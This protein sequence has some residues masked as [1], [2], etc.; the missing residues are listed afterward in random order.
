MLDWLVTAQRWLYGDLSAQLSAFASTRNWMTLA[1]VLPLGI[2]F[3]AIHALTPGHSKGILAS[4]LIGSRLNVFRAAG[5]A[6]T[7]AVVHVTSAVILALLAAPLITRTIGGV[8]RAP[9]LDLISRS[10]LLAIGVWLVARAIRGKSHLHGEGIA[11]GVVAGLVP[12]PLTLFAM[13]Y[14]LSRDV[15]EAGIAFAA[16]M[17]I[18]VGIT[19]SLVALAA[20]LT[21]SGFRRFIQSTTIEHVSRTVEALGGLLLAVTAIWSLLR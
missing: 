18:G 19:L 17:M 16:A 2:V 15:P 4:Y 5:V 10:I 9:A 20:V 11:V 14:S 8:G 1:A 3:G 21:R 12:C 13:F 6:W 7:L